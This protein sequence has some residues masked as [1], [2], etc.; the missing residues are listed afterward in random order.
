MGHARRSAI[1]DAFAALSIEPTRRAKVINIYLVRQAIKHHECSPLRCHV[2]GQ[3][4]DMVSYVLRGESRRTH[5][6]IIPASLPSL[7]FLE[8]TG[9]AFS[10]CPGLAA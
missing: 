5:M 8:A 3:Q 7:G 1:I 4:K 2:G 9:F 6:S 10:V